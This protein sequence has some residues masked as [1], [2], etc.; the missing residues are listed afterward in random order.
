MGF[1]Q[2]PLVFRMGHSFVQLIAAGGRRRELWR[3]TLPV[4][5]LSLPGPLLTPVLSL[6]SADG[7]HRTHL[8]G[9]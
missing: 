9:L 7:K 5:V 1:W 3:Q 8:T 4:P 2:K 6:S